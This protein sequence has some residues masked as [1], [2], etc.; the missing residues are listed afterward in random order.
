MFKCLLA[1]ARPKWARGKRIRESDC[2]LPSPVSYLQ[3]QL[4]GEVHKF[5]QGLIGD[6]AEMTK[7]KPEIH[8]N[9]WRN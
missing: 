5:W 1:V 8:R 4:P 7:D 2:A 9:T 6:M 3:Q